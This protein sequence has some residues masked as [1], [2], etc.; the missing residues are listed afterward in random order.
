MQQGWDSSAVTMAILHTYRTY[1][2][3][4]TTHAFQFT[5]ATPYRR[6]MHNEVFKL[7]LQYLSAAILGANSSI[8]RDFQQQNVRGRKG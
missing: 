1:K 5:K 4:L 6:R 7:L 2:I 3:R 8:S